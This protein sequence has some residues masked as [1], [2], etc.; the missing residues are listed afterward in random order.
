MTT[1]SDDQRAD[2]NARNVGS[3][4]HDLSDPLSYMNALE[5]AALA[6]KIERCPHCQ[7]ETHLTPMRQRLGGG[8]SP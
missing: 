5:A 7:P 3:T 4:G 8:G 1:E 2:R 6:A